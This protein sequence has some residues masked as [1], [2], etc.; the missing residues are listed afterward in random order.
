[1]RKFFALALL[2][3]VANVCVAQFT[4]SFSDGNFT[5]N[6]VWSGNSTVFLVNGTNQLQLTNTA[7]A[8][9]YVSSSFS[10]PDLSQVE[11]EWQVY[12]KQTFSSSGSNY[13]RVYLVSDQSNLTQPLNG[14]YLQF[15][16][17]GTLDA[18]ELFRQS[19]TSSLS[20]CRATNGSL[21]SSFGV[22]VKVL[23]DGSGNWQ[24]FADYSGGA[25]FV[26]EA[27]G[28]DA[29]HTSSSFT[30]VQCV[31][32]ITNAN[33]F[34]Y[35]DFLI[36]NTPIPD[37][38]PPT[39][40][41]IS[42]VSSS[43]ID[44]LF[45]EA[46]DLM[47]S[48]N[49]F[50]YSM[51]Q[52]IGIP[53]TAI[54]QSDNKTV[55]IVFNNFFKN[56]YQH[57]LSMS[58]IKD[59]AG[60]MISPLTKSFLYL[61]PTTA[62][63][64]DIII[65]EFF[66]DPNPVIGLPDQEFIEIYNRSNSPFDLAGW[67]LTDRSSTATF[68]S[69]IILPH[70]YWIVTSSAS[71][72]LFTPLG[73]TMGVSN[74][75]T[76]NNNGDKIILIDPTG[77]R[78]DSLTYNLKWYNDVDKQQGGWTLEL[79]NSDT[80]R[81]D[82][83]NWL[84]S[85]DVTGG[86]P[87]KQNS[88]F[89]NK[90]D[91][92]PPLWVDLSFLN[93]HQLKIEIN[94]PLALSSIQNLNNFKSDQYGSP[95]STTLSANKK[96][97][98]LSFQNS[99]VNGVADTL[100]ISGLTDL[101]GN[102]I[103]PS[104]K[105]FLYFQP[106]PVSPKD[107]IIN[108]FM[109]D[110]TPIVGLPEAEYIELFNRSANPIDLANW[111]LSDG[112]S[113][114][115][116]LS[117]VIMPK[118]YWIVTSSSVVQQFASLE[119]VI[120]LSGFPSLNNNGDKIL[121]FDPSGQKIDS[122]TYNLKWFNDVDKQ[123]GG[124]SLELLNSDTVRYDSANWLPSLDV[125]G[126]TPGK[127]NSQ[128]GK[129]FDQT[130]PNL[131]SVTAIGSTQL[132][133]SFNEKV[134]QSSA[135]SL[136]NYTVNNQ[137]GNPQSAVLSAD[138]RSVTLLF[139]TGFKNGISNSISLVGLSDLSGNLLSSTQKDFLYFIAQPVNLKDILITE[140]MADPAPVVGL[141]EAEY[142]EIY[143]R[144]SNPIDLLNWTLTDGGPPAKFPSK[145]I[146]P[147]E[148]FII[149]SSASSQFNAYPNK[150][151]LSTFP[152]LNN[153]SDSIVLRSPLSITIDSVAYST[154]WYRSMEKQ[155]GGWSLEIIDPQNTC[156][157]E[158]NWTASYD[159]TGGSPGKQNS[160][161]ANKPDLTGPKLLSVVVVQSNELLLKFD[162]KLE[163]QISLTSFTLVPDIT[164]NKVK[165]KG[166][167]LR[168]I[169]LT[170]AQE[171]SN[172]KLYTIRVK[173]LRDCNGNSI[174]EEFNS[175]EFALPEAGDSLDLV[176]NEILFN[177]RPNGVDFVEMYN[178]SP[179]YINLKKWKLANS[180]N[181]MLKN[182]VEITSDNFILSPYSHL[183]LT[184]DIEV[185]KNNYPN[186]LS[187]N[188]LEANLPSLPDDEGSIAIVNEEGKIIDQFLYA[189]NFHSSLLKD[190]EGVS[191]ERISFF[192]S[193]QEKN[194]WQSA[195]SILG[196]ATPGYLNSNARPETTIDEA[197]VVIEPEVFSPD[198]E[199]AKINF[200]FDQSGF[201]ANVKVFD[202]QG[203]LVKTIANNETLNHEGFFRWDGD[204]EDG[205][206]ARFGYYVVW[207]EIFDPGGFSKI[208]RNRVVVTGN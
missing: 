176:L 61:V 128:N 21:A 13:G 117:K 43:T 7:A 45:S 51:D 134:E 110:P 195:N 16:E 102:F 27:S 76:L 73:K 154:S 122:L 56:G 133:L 205:I 143:N 172:R 153:G 20:V 25:T 109:A 28:I 31:Y 111:S 183:A 30:G 204:R 24:I 29:T 72:P 8:T 180:E 2:F 184:E 158:S 46:I 140:I 161:N 96:T 26:L 78:V 101:S 187:G 171:L 188:F 17:A 85:N 192:Q 44:L 201:S 170:L 182:R 41:N 10:I 84:A 120:G 149:H 160:V 99:F 71:A 69:Q 167:A 36:V 186:N 106:S 203:R 15:G 194:N 148:Y 91:Q 12:V 87:G 65:N 32:T 142:I 19:G 104:K 141:P 67:K 168:E 42:V 125:S 208:Y 93:D 83:A 38:T 166:K 34:F 198:T 121:L 49:I 126:G 206:K 77:L 146:Q 178:N 63:P 86:T 18:I 130:P 35:D 5:S 164:L 189:K 52:N 79:L 4:D 173:T 88:Q 193:S 98:T 197:R 92:T 90:F 9:S 138:K 147:K 119:H 144:S 59:I 1:M 152:S 114:A 37:T 75:P 6:P 175:L 151:G 155:D 11:T 14:Y 58:G 135:Q 115:T 199:F 207:F 162:E 80:I 177:P 150:I 66:P 165:F 179:K 163:K 129:F 82:S 132:Q 68:P 22:R 74:F 89:G 70:E 60:N 97:I 159:I 55:R 136:L 112:T 145:I 116:F 169:K 124:W 181:G 157:E 200:R 137:I 23:R 190:E 174:Q 131:I 118:D 40:Q 50:N 108:E 202:Q 105:G 191:L 107:I 33:K 53:V 64:K 103:V 54:L 113:R 139:Q 81:Y 127:K 156:G 3:F 95:V 62:K 185:V 123:Q 39:L 94:E 100:S 48:T 57:Q 196:F 47:A